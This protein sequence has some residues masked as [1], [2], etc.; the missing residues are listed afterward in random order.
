MVSDCPIHKSVLIT[1]IQTNLSWSVLAVDW[2]HDYAL[3]IS[4]NMI[5]VYFN[6]CDIRGNNGAIYG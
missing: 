2:T 1:F 4:C 6:C 5:S 3:P